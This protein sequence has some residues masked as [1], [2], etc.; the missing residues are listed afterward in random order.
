MV[1]LRYN[2][3]KNVDRTAIERARIKLRQLGFD[4]KGTILYTTKSITRQEK[5]TNVH[6]F[7]AIDPAVEQEMRDATEILARYECE[8]P[9]KI[10]SKKHTAHFNGDSESHFVIIERTEPSLNP[11]VLSSQ[12]YEIVDTHFL[13]FQGLL[14]EI[15]KGRLELEQAKQNLRKVLAIII[16]DTKERVGVDP[17]LVLDSQVIWRASDPLTDALLT[18]LVSV[19]SK[20]GMVGPNFVNLP[21]ENLVEPVY[22]DFHGHPGYEERWL[23]P[24]SIGDIGS[25]YYGSANS[26]ETQTQLTIQ[27]VSL[28]LK[29]DEFRLFMRPYLRGESWV[30][31]MFDPMI[32]R[33]AY[34][35]EVYNTTRERPIGEESW[36]V[37]GFLMDISQKFQE[38][39]ELIVKVKS[40][41]I[42]CEEY[43]NDQVSLLKTWNEILELMERTV[44]AKFIPRE[45]WQQM[46]WGM[47]G[48][49]LNL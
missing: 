39:A 25:A 24:P 9:I 28:R 29:T 27:A 32:V 4:G 49:I 18:E 10:Q 11:V 3:I 15:T 16:A 41:R 35:N 2:E 6:V 22:F 20:H 43:S 17:S 1:V 8:F 47:S 40:F 30:V 14:G 38:N 13:T 36:R 21:D 7:V 31:A 5:Q 46:L 37:L 44:S 23:I 34:L 42:N 12:G 33:I 26:D 45:N 48:G 19:L